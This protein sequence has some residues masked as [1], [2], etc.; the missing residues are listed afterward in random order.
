MPPTSGNF[1]SLESILN[2]VRA[3]CNDSFAG[4]TGT[5]GEGQILTDLVPSTTTNNPFLLNHL[6]SAIRELYREL[7]I[8]GAGVIIQDNYILESL[9]IIDGSLGPGI[10][11]A[12]V[13]TYLDN[14]GYFDGTTLH[15]S[16]TLPSDIIRPIRIWERTSSTIDTF[17]PMNQVMNGLPPRNQLS[18]LIEWEWRYEKIY[19][20]GALELRDIR[21]RYVATLPT[22][23][24]TPLNPTT[25][26]VPVIDS[27]DYVAYRTAEKIALSLGNPQI[28][29]ALN[30][31][32][33]RFMQQLKNERVLNMQ[34]ADYYARR[35][36]DDADTANQLDVYGI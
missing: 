34:E 31:A 21:I 1:P 14:T 2:N 7:R 20:V 30:T 36:Y 5:P 3:I 19:F 12:A 26:Y 9:P 6:N 11:D 10:P 32:A 24:S 16:L 27:D 22:F 33:M 17:I 18:R 4:A 23:F 25:T 8:T 13:Q 28:S 15:P 29:A 35:P